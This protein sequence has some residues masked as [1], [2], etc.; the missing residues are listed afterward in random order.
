[1]TSAFPFSVGDVSSEVVILNLSVHKFNGLKLSQ[2]E[3][4]GENLSRSIPKFLPRSKQSIRPCFVPT[5]VYIRV[6]NV[7]TYMRRGT[8]FTFEIIFFP[9]PPFSPHIQGPQE[10]TDKWRRTLK[11]SSSSSLSLSLLLWQCEQAIKASP[12]AIHCAG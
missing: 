11:S 12:R 3:T 6:E 2:K 9:L 7:R 1:M 10:P 5:Y 8:M 4:K